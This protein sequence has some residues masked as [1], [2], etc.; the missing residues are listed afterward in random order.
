LTCA[1]GNRV[2]FFFSF[3]RAETFFSWLYFILYST[4]SVLKT[5]VQM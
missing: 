3:V 5:R 2:Y 1:H 4:S